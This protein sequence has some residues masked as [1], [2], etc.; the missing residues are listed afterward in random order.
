MC[1]RGGARGCTRLAGVHRGVHKG[2]CTIWDVCAWA[3]C[4]M[5]CLRMGCLYAGLCRGGA[6]VCGG[7]WGTCVHGM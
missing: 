6:H 3:V 1:A 7:V 4:V 5:G 2:G